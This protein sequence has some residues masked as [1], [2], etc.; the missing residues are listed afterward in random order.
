VSTGCTL[1]VGRAIVGYNLKW[2]DCLDSNVV[3]RKRPVPKKNP[4]WSKS[5]GQPEVLNL[6]T[7]IADLQ[8]TF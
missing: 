5:Q 4:R 1:V 6:D 2:P 8:A 7:M 3:G